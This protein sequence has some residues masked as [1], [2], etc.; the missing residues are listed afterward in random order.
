MDQ[1]AEKSKMSW[2]LDRY[3]VGESRA[4]SDWG[5]QKEQV[6]GQIADETEYRE[7]S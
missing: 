6:A 1:D 3:D 4:A 7:K 5:I 2:R